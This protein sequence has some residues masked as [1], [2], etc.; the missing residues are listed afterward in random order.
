MDLLPGTCMNSVLHPTTGQFDLPLASPAFISYRLR[1]P[2]PRLQM[3][4]TLNGSSEWIQQACSDFE[5]ATGVPMEHAESDQS[6]ALHGQTDC[7]W[8]RELE[9]ED[10]HLG[11]LRIRQSMI[12]L[13]TVDP[14]VILRMADIVGDLL[15][16]ALIENR[17]NHEYTE[18]V[19]ELIDAASQSASDPNPIEAINRLLRTALELTSFRSVGF[20][21]L[22][23]DAS[24]LK[25]KASMSID[26]GRI[27]FPLRK[28]E[29]AP[30]DF[31]VLQQ[32]QVTLNSET[33]SSELIWMPPG[34]RIGL[35]LPVTSGEKPLG[36]LWFF[37]RRQRKISDRETA[38]IGSI[39]SQIAASLDRAVLQRGNRRSEQIQ[40]ELEQV[41]ASEEVIANS[42]FD[43]PDGLDVDGFCS[44]RFEIGGDF[45]DAVR[46]DSN[47]V[48]IAIADAC[49]HSI[50]AAMISSVTRGAFRSVVRSLPIERVRTE[51]VLSELNE[52]IYDL[53][54]MGRFVTMLLL[55]IDTRT[56]MM[57]ISSAGHPPPLRVSSSGKT[58]SITG[59]QDLMLGAIPQHDYQRVNY[60]LSSGDFLVLFTDGITEAQNARRSMFRDEGIEAVV[61][62]QSWSSSSDVVDAVNR[63]M[64]RHTGTANQA[65]DRTLVVLRYTQPED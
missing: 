30:Y 11:Q 50:P 35:G 45:F 33:G 22:S 5:Q 62:D 61:R 43:L 47:R 63:K 44:S 18:M 15:T 60:Q 59:S 36:T 3:R 58:S 14:Q 53:V 9:R 27:P 16:N 10:D 4:P 19:S 41:G 64:E 29:D 40:K 12:S 48:M 24:E 21:L 52:V 1:A 56:G 25:L 51:V 17:R 55:L 2:G 8:S 42:K 31:R 32:S 6:V 39:S 37:D 7:L 54:P 26:A 23:P 65:D 49:G 20:F 28:V 34:A 57:Q 38:V 13:A 46:I